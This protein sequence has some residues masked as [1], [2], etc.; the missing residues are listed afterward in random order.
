MDNSSFSRF[1]NLKRKL[2]KSIK[3]ADNGITEQEFNTLLYQDKNS[4]S[5]NEGL[6]PEELT[7][8]I[9]ED[10]EII[11][12]CDPGTNIC[13]FISEEKYYELAPALAS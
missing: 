9:L 11:Y 12:V 4:F 7:T 8:I 3:N 2:L 10:S 13:R 1:I 5:V 6:T